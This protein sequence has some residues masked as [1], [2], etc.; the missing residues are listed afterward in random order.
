M[1][2]VALKDNMLLKELYLCDNK[3]Q[4]T[5]ANYISSIIKD[6]KCLEL[7]DLRNNNLQDSGLSTIC[8]GLSEQIDSHHGLRNLCIANNYITASG[9]SYLA[10]AL[11]I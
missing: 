7:L 4:P 3:I 5:D 9:V 2:S 11:V 10:K 1:M 6:N 8:S